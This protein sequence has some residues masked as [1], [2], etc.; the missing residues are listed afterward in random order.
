MSIYRQCIF[1]YVFMEIFK[2]MRD[3][4]TLKSGQGLP[5]WRKGKIW[6]SWSFNSSF[7]AW[8]FY[9]SCMTKSNRARW[10]SKINYVFSECLKY[11]II[12]MISTLNIS[13]RKLSLFSIHYYWYKNT[14]NKIIL[15]FWRLLAYICVEFSSRQC[16][17]SNDLLFLCDYFKLR[18]LH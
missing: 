1:V 5:L 18:N 11:F 16:T 14:N 10:Y 17:S 8:L 6:L 15:F 13:L 4:Q 9:E 3:W 12:K 7:I 2:N